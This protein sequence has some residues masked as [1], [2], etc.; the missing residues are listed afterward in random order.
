MLFVD[1]DYQ[2]R[3]NVYDQFFNELNQCRTIQLEY[4]QSLMK[5]Q[6]IA[7][8]LQVVY[9]NYNPINIKKE[10]VKIFSYCNKNNM[11][12]YANYDVK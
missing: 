8:N 3:I 4:P 2:V 9:T 10:F 7:F 11:I 5:V 1:E 12:F 6:I